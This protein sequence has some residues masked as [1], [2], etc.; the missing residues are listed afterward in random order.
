MMLLSQHTRSVGKRK[1]GVRGRKKIGWQ[2]TVDPAISGGPVE[3]RRMSRGGPKQ[4]FDGS[5]RD[6]QNFSN[7][8]Y[9]QSCVT[10]IE[11]KSIAFWMHAKRAQNHVFS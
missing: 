10:T 9:M 1:N 5:P 11:P 7:A 6:S 3:G 8:E 4:R 2:S